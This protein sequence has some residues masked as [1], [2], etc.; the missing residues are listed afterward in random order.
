MIEDDGV[1]LMLL[2]VVEDLPVARDL[3]SNTLYGQFLYVI[4]MIVYA[5]GKEGLWFHPKS[6]VQERTSSQEVAKKLLLIH[7]I[8]P[9]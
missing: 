8:H 7:S 1:A 5:E 4:P 3:L 6:T 9:P 2:F